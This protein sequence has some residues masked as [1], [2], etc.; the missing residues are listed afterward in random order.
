MPYQYTEQGLALQDE[1]KT[2]MDDHILSLIH[3]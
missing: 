2:F 1:V 3:I